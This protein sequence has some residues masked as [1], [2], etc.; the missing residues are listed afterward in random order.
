MSF[1][2]ISSSEMEIM[3]YL[4]NIQ[5]P[6]GTSELMEYFNTNRKKDWK[7]QTMHTFLKR[8][9][10]KGLVQ[11]QRKGKGYLYSYALTEEQ[12]EQKKAKN[13]LAKM[14]DNSMHKFLTALSGGEKLSKDDIAEL[15]SWLSGEEDS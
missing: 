5:R 6:I 2:D 15:K 10:D 7:I 8:L 12:F 3:E 9:C 14:Y 13:V 4:W 11:K 1:Q